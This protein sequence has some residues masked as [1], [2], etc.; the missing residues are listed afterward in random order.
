M[1]RNTL[2]VITGLLIGNIAIMGLHYLGMI[3]YPLPEGSNMNDMTAIAEYIK[4]APAGALL[5]VIVAHIGGTF[6]A[7]ISTALVSKNNITAYIVGGFFT[8]AG[9]YNLY[10][11]PSPWWFNI[12]VI[13]YL[14]AAFYGFNLVAEKN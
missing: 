4:I 14:P 10:M 12:E 9:I 1:I 11:L 13:L 8:L 3:F 5:M 6:L 2:A 7:G